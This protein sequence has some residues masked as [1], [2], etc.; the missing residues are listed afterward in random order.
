[1]VPCV[2][3]S[4]MPRLTKN[5]GSM[6]EITEVL[7]SSAGFFLNFVASLNLRRV[8]T[9]TYNLGCIL[10]LSIVLGHLGILPSNHLYGQSQKTVS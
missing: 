6:K 4:E 3:H 8:T 10:D 2:L 5:L 9:Y 1:M 7:L